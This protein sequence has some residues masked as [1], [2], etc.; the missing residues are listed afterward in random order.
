MRG[1]GLRGPEPSDDYAAWRPPARLPGR[2][3]IGSGLGLG[4]G[5]VWVWS[6]SGRVWVW[7][8]SWSGQVWPGLV[9]S[10]S[11]LSGSGPVWVWSVWVWSG[12]GLVRVWS[13]PVRVWSGLVWVWSGRV[14]LG[15]VRVWSGSGWRGRG[16]GVPRPSDDHVARAT[17]PPR[18]MTGVPGLPGTLGRPSTRPPGRRGSCR[19][20]S[21]PALARSSP[22]PEGPLRPRLIP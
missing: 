14:W 20:P 7:V 8:W 9:W 1:R 18:G 11:G 5:L 6:W 22:G 17:G 3:Y 2:V 12:L 15:L 19:D 16:R 21:N 4:L 13:G 10:W